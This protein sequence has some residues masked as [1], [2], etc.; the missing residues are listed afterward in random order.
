MDARVCLVCSHA[1]DAFELVCQCEAKHGICSACF[2][3]S[4]TPR[5]DLIATAA[6][7]WSVMG[8]AHALEQR[9]PTEGGEYTYMGAT[10]VSTGR[11]KPFLEAAIKARKDEME[12]EARVVSGFVCLGLFLCLLVAG[13]NMGATPLDAFLPWPLSWVARPAYC[14]VDSFGGTLEEL[15]MV[16]SMFTL[17]LSVLLI[18]AL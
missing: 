16:I 2:K 4:G 7:G 1:S 11:M 3:A 14:L 15:K 12:G 8:W 17:L 13:F 9:C 18:R 10:A 6:Y 5:D